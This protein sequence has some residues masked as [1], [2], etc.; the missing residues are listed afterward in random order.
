MLFQVIKG[1]LEGTN[2]ENDPNVLDISIG[3]SPE[4]VWHLIGS[5][6][7]RKH[8]RVFKEGIFWYIEDCNST[9]GV[10]L[11]RHR[12]GEKARLENGDTI[13]L[14]TVK[15]QFFYRPG[16][17][18]DAPSDTEVGD[19][20]LKKSSFQR[21]F[22]ANGEKTKLI[23]GVIIGD[24]KLENQIGRGGMG[25]VWCAMQI[26]TQK[27]VALKILHNM[28]KHDPREIKQFKNEMKLL[29]KINHPNIVR[30][31]GSGKC[32]GLNYLAMEYLTGLPLHKYVYKQK[33]LNEL[34]S[35]LIT[36]QMASALSEIWQK[37]HIIHRDIKPENI[38]GCAPGVFK[39]M[40]L[41]ISCGVHD[42][43]N[44]N[45][46]PEGTPEFMS[47]EQIQSQMLDFKSDIYSLGGTLYYMLANDFPYTA[48]S[49]NV[50]LTQV[51][52]D[53]PPSIV[54][55]KPQVSNNTNALILR[56]MAKKPSKRHASYQQLIQE[57]DDCIKFIYAKR[58]ES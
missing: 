26:S 22:G 30:F 12:I 29:Q 50:L 57:I 31:V 40:D 33:G 15:F 14:G 28:E 41:G 52:N 44:M 24:Y 9:N 32:E 1:A 8:A 54:R 39:L 49:Q 7:S 5:G 10:R 25:E 35:L 45:S 19:T 6:V 55:K 34:E 11:N 27:R 21:H 4:N 3:S 47:P 38:M 17:T 37:Y 53:P 23:P 48:S 58:K 13:T 56:M 18:T 20:K 43:S 2:F 16:I 46:I 51:L 42:A 36:R